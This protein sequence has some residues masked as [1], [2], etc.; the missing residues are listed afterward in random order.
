MIYETFLKRNNGYITVFVCMLMPLFLAL[1]GICIDGSI[2]LYND[3]KLMTATKFAAISATAFYDV[4]DGSVVLKG[5]NDSGAA[6]DAATNAL[7]KNFSGA[8]VYEFSINNSK[9]NECTVKAK[10]KVD[11]FFARIFH[12]DSTTIEEIYTAERDI[13]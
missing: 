4:K 8:W 6:R 11:F 10:V 13:N 1:L 7:E 3:A 2:I 9:K 5:M 12:F